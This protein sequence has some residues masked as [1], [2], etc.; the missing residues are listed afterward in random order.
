M[1]ITIGQALVQ[2]QGED[3]R[4]GVLV[5]ERNNHM[6]NE[7]SRSQDGMIDHRGMIAMRYPFAC[8]LVYEVAISLTWYEAARAWASSRPHSLVSPY[9]ST[10][11]R[12]ISESAS[13]SFACFGADGSSCAIFS[14]AANTREIGRPRVIASF[15]RFQLD[16]ARASAC[17]SVTAGGSE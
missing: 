11:S 13:G 1:M 8:H 4:P 2:V 9:P 16:F 10:A 7:P 17:C 12:R 15:R 14:R 6:P 3:G 5:R